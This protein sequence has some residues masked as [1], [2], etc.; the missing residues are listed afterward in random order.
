MA[1]MWRDVREALDQDPWTTLEI[2][3]LR[4]AVRY[5]LDRR[6]TP[7]SGYNT[8]AILPERRKAL[9]TIAGW[10]VQEDC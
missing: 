1:H 7:P 9:D 6:S 3:Y 8:S 4:K 5:R 2:R 10:Y